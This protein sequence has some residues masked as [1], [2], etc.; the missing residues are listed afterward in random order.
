[1]TTNPE[2][3]IASSSIEPTQQKFTRSTQA[4]YRALR[5]LQVLETQT[6]RNNPI[7]AAE[8]IAMLTHGDEQAPAITACRKSV[9]GIIGALRAT[10][11]TIKSRGNRGIY[12]ASRCISDADLFTIAQA[13]TRYDAIPL[14]KRT[15]LVAQIIALGTPTL[16]TEVCERRMPTASV[17]DEHETSEA[18]EKVL[19]HPIEELIGLAISESWVLTAEIEPAGNNDS[20]VPPC[21]RRE[22]IKFEPLRV[23][24]EHGATYVV[25]TTT[26]CDN[27]AC[28]SKVIGTDRIRSLTARADRGAIHIARSGDSGA[29]W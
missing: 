14:Q 10:G 17:K 5:V 20:A 26:L 29:S 8:L 2:A 15:Q 28:S 12:L 27:G 3:Q 4:A 11:Y 18:Y 23:V 19:L 13:I 25:G 16:K 24:A 7:T 1:M 9:Y 21:A 6:D 22:R